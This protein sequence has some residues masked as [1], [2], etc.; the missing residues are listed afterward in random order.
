MERE[1]KK[2]RNSRLTRDD[3]TSYALLAPYILLFAVFILIP[4]MMTAGLSFTNFDVIN[5]PRFNGI[6]NYLYLFTQDTVF[7]FQG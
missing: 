2:R 1:I 4:V 3:L 7:K 5:P 6:A